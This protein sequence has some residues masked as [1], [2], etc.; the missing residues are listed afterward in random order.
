MYHLLCV[1]IYYYELVCFLENLNGSFNFFAPVVL[2]LCLS[3]LVL[4]NIFIKH[5]WK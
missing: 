3:R 1:Y 5:W 2:G 4:G